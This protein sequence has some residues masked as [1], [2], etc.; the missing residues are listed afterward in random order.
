MGCCSITPRH[1]EDTTATKQEEAELLERSSSGK[2]S[3]TEVQDEV[4]LCQQKYGNLFEHPNSPESESEQLPE[5]LLK[6]AMMQAPVLWVKT[7]Q[8]IHKQIYQEPV[9]AWEGAD[10]RSL[11]EIMWSSVVQLRNHHTLEVCE[12]YLVLLSFHLLILSVDHTGH[13]FTYQGI[14]PLS[15]IKIRALT[16]DSSSLNMFEITVPMAETKIVACPSP[17]EFKIWMSS[18]KSRIEKAAT[19]PSD[20]SYSTLSFLIPCDEKWKKKEL[21]RHIMHSPIIHWEGTPIQ[22]LGEVGYMS[23]VKVYNANSKEFEERIMIQFPA[24][25]VF[26]STDE[27]KTAIIYKGRLPL[28]SIKAIERSALMGRLE[29]EITGEMMESIRVS[30]SAA[31]DYQ[32]WLFLL[33]KVLAFIF[34]INAMFSFVTCKHL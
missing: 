14:L 11:G 20:N 4:A 17:A 30:C 19:L 27:Q 21:T 8:E 25:L 6:G 1:T 33:Q 15:G 29:F 26:L 23:M 7:R 31:E 10:I 13:T 2:W 18:L 24:D 5:E 32:E 9:N 22:H 12:R 28:N 3:F 16:N 34:I